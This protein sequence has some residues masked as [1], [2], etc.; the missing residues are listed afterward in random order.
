MNNPIDIIIIVLVIA[1]IGI[2]ITRYSHL[3]LDYL[4]SDFIIYYKYCGINGSESE[5]RCYTP[6]QAC[7][8]LYRMANNRGLCIVITDV[9]VI[10]KNR[11]IKIPIDLWR[12]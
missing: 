5:I 12:D 10:D 9:I 3:I 1:I 8:L 11:R 6:R 4:K 7:K 2:L